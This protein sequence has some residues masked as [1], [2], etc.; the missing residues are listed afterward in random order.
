MTRHGHFFRHSEASFWK[1][2]F[3]LEALVMAIC[4]RSR[5]LF[6]PGRRSWKICRQNPCFI[7]FKRAIKRLNALCF[8]KAKEAEVVSIRQLRLANDFN[9]PIAALRCKIFLVFSQIQLKKF[10]TA[11]RIL[12]FLFFYLFFNTCQ[13]DQILMSR[14]EKQTVR[15]H[16]NFDNRIG[17]MY[18]AA[19]KKLKYSQ[20]RLGERTF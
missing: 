13:C 19:C 20:Q 1:A 8:E 4:F 14:Y 17:D 16:T 5:R 18:I 7:V 2:T 12:R 11:R 10:Q 6:V 3:H 9:D 15:K